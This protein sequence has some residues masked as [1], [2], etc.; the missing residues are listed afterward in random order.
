MLGLSNTTQRK[1][2]LSRLLYYY[3]GD[4]VYTID[5]KDAKAGRGI[6]H[7]HVVARPTEFNFPYHSRADYTPMVQA[8]MED[9]IRNA[10]IADDIARESEAN[11]G[12]ILVISGGETQNRILS[13]ALAQRGV[14]TVTFDDTHSSREFDEDESES[15]PCP[16]IRVPGQ[17]TAV[18][19]SADAVNKCGMH[20]DA[21]TVFL[22]FPLYFRKMLADTLREI[23]SSGRNG[24]GRLKIFDYVDRR[25]GLLENYF[26]MRSYNYGVHPD[27]LLGP[28]QN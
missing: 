26:R 21:S 17:S 20:L 25:I 7:A 3:I 27:L 12:P 23:N 8:L 11:K 5:E 6:I 16:E 18:L 22:A 9:P 2:K 4:V 14:K 1:D 28:D 10:A 24:D 19:V 15:V 13:E